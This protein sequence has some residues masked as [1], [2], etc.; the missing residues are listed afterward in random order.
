MENN[1]ENRQKRLL[2][3][4]RK[5]EEKRISSLKEY[6]QMMLLEKLTSMV[7]DMGWIMLLIPRQ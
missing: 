1:K 5:L 2:R 7:K 6:Q 4:L 3:R